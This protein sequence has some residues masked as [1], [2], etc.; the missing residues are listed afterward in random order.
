QDPQGSEAG[1]SADRAT[2]DVRAGHQP[3]GGKRDRDP[4][5]AGAALPRRQGDRMTARGSLFRKYVFYFVVVVSAALVAS[6]A[7]GLYFAYQEN[8]S[9]LL[10]L[11]REKAAGA[12]SR[13]EAYV[14][15]I[16]H[17]LGWMRLP[18]LGGAS[19]EQRR[20]DFLK[21]LRQVPAITDLSHLD[22]SG[23]ELLRV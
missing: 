15:E 13:I 16:E 7:V 8:K 12:A 21:L 9:D 10:A 4:A 5:F 11:E 17:Q 20:I 18:Q 3:Q 22:R 1:G 6:G 2:D 23:I 19:L 14:Q